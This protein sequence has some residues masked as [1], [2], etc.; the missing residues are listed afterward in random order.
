MTIRQEVS[1]THILP[2]PISVV[3]FTCS[4][5]PSSCGKTDA[6]HKWSR[7]QLALA[8]AIKMP[9]STV[10]PTE[11]GR[12]PLSSH[13]LTCSPLT[14]LMSG[15]ACDSY[16]PRHSGAERTDLQQ[17]LVAAGGVLERDDEAGAGPEDAHAGRRLVAPRDALQLVA[18]PHAEDGADLRRTQASQTRSHYLGKRPGKQ[19][20]TD[21]HRRGLGLTVSTRQTQSSQNDALG[22]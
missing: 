16:H 2:S 18:R 13:Q 21:P 9:G 5:L 15:E 17:E 22:A 4:H 3:S 6:H 12:T 14:T 8:Q 19:L 7:G 10:Q 20:L 11:Q 1:A